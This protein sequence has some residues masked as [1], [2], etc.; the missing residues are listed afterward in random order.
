MNFSDKVADKTAKVGILGLGY[1]G[2][3]LAL[4]VH[5]VGLPVLGLDIDTRRVEQLNAGKSPIKH[6][7]GD[8]INAM[9]QGGFEATTDFS[10]AADHRGTGQRRSLDHPATGRRCPPAA[11]AN[12]HSSTRRFH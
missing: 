12:R 7:S 11:P 1:V 9:R 8:E 10:R 4:R 5:E 3:P 2:I 6:I